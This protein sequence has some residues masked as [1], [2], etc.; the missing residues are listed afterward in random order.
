[1]HVYKQIGYETNCIIRNNIIEYK[2]TTFSI[3]WFTTYAQKD[4]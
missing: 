2:Y 3:R 4:V 1:M